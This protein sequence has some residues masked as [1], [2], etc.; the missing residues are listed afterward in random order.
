MIPFLLAP[1]A[2]LGVFL[3]VALKSRADP[4]ADELGMAFVTADLDRAKAVTA[5]QQWDLLQEAMKGRQPFN[6]PIDVW[7]DEDTGIGGAGRHDDQTNSWNW[8]LVYQCASS[9]A[10]FCLVIDDIIIQ[11]IEGQPKVVS[12]GK[13][14]EA[15]DYR[16]KCQEM[17][18]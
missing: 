15:H 5:P 3:F 10:R 11:N 2:F 16:Y 12:W 13:M 7:F 14:C 6:C 18:Q 1:L 17:C 9:N 8:G 4:P